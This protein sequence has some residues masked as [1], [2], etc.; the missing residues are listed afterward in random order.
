MADKKIF[1]KVVKYKRLQKTGVDK[2]A[3]LM[4]KA[5]LDE[6]DW[7]R[8]TNLVLEYH[9]YKKEIIIS[10]RTDIP[11][12]EE[13]VIEDIEPVSENEFETELQDIAEKIDSIE[14]G[15]ETG[16]FITV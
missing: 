13:T 12:V 15:Q 11:E 4:P 14:D 6:M 3:V 8:A 9:P 2:L 16:Q 1:N 5:W 7:T 10:Q